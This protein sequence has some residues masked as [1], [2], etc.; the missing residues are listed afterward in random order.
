MRIIEQ[1]VKTGKTTQLVEWLREDRDHRVIVVASERQA[2]NVQRHF[3]L[4][5]DDVLS[6]PVLLHASFRR[7][8]RRRAIGVDEL[9]AVLRTLLG[10][11]EVA[12]LSKRKV[13]QTS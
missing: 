12:T 8:V 5:P 6:V 4:G 13:W 9:D 3:D 7:A 10:D 1:E 2:R 11:V